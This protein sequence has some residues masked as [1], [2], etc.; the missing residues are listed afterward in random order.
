MKRYR[1]RTTSQWGDITEMRPT[2]AEERGK[3]PAALIGLG[4]LQLLV[5]IA[6]LSMVFAAIVGGGT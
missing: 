6:V 2:Q 5:V 4:C 1:I 3:S